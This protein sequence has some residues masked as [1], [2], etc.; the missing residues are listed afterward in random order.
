MDNI[1]VIELVYSYMNTFLNKM[2]QQ[3]KEKVQSEEVC[4]YNKTKKM[5]LWIMWWQGEKHMPEIIQMCYHSIQKNFDREDIQIH[6]I[7]QENVFEYVDI[8]LYI[9]NK[10]QSG[11]ISLTHFSDIIRF[12]LLS[13]NGGMWM[14]IT[15]YVTDSLFGTAEISDEF[16]T[17]KMK[18]VL[19]EGTVD[20]NR[21]SINLHK[22][23]SHTLLFHYI[24]EALLFYWERHDKVLN[25]YILDYIVAVAYENLP[26]VRAQIDGCAPSNEAMFEL[27]NYMNTVYQEALYQKLCENTQFFKLSY[28][29][30]YFESTEDEK[31][32]F[33]HVLRNREL[34]DV[35]K[36]MDCITDG[37]DVYIY[38]ELIR[39]L[40]PNSVLDAGMFLQRIGAVSRQAMNCEIASDIQ[41]VGIHT[42]Q[43]KVFPV[44]HQIYNEIIEI[45]SFLQQK[46][47]SKSV[48]VV[49]ALSLQGRL[50][51]TQEQQLVDY[52][53]THARCI[54]IDMD[55]AQL[56]HRIQ[57]HCTQQQSLQVDSKQY[58]LAYCG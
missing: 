34:Q 38:F 39:Q 23:N 43:Q 4:V 32:T 16:W 53:V 22:G 6:L 10:F 20:K 17:H 26:Y 11:E 33:Y 37:T 2:T 24:Y 21:W 42:K 19:W 9:V 44:Y 47:I 52:A 8:P 48:D 3:Y 1:N 55:N 41:L 54:V 18:D 25:Y 50:Q 49:M 46:E 51:G 57:Q 45:D 7:T 5:P 30:D 27:R 12:G 31:D 40:Q 13:Q 36:E 29:V 58:L 35:R 28:K 15:Y 56:I 14:D